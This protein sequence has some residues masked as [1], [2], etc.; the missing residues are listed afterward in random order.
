MK[1]YTI[2]DRKV[3]RP[4]HALTELVS[5]A[6]PPARATREKKKRDVDLP[7]KYY[8]VQEPF[9]LSLYVQRS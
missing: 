3:F 6:A 7:D 4:L 2:I 5:N 8:V 1:L 9:L